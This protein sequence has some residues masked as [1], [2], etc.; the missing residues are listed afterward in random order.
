MLGVYFVESEQA[1]GT[2]HDAVQLE[3]ITKQIIH[4]HRC[5][6]DFLLA[7]QITSEVFS[8]VPYA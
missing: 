4:T 2:T 1:K 8:S 3:F 6:P 7:K 5:L